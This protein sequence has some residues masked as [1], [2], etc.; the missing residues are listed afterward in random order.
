MREL[1]QDKIND[2]LKQYVA[3]VERSIRDVFSTPI[4]ERQVRAVNGADEGKVASVIGRVGWGQHNY[5]D[6]P[7]DAGGRPEVATIVQRVRQ[8]IK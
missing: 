8:A 1:V 6:V 5:V 4:G 3:V 7:L 2:V